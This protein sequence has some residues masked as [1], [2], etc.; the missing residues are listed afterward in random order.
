MNEIL[1]P[2]DWQALW[3]SI[4][5]AAISSLLLL[6]ISLPLAWWLSRMAHPVRVLLESLIALPLILPPT[7]LGFYLLLLFSPNSWVGQVW[8]RLFDSQLA[9]SFE[10]VVIGSMIYSLPFVVQ[11]LQQAFHRIPGHLLEV[12]SSMGLAPHEKFTKVIFPLTRASIVA[13]VTLGFA[14]TIGEFGVVLMIG[15]NIPDETRVISIALYDHVETLEYS[16]A[17]QV[18]AVLVILSLVILMFTYS[19]FGNPLR[20]SIDRISHD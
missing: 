14:H 8:F 19:R 17:H 18:S 13:A 9:F 6:I 4:K 16:S 3:L 11:P 20:W 7:V 5:L 15:G 2:A 10:A 1:T 12:Y